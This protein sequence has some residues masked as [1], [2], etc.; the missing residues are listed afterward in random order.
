MSRLEPNLV[1]PPVIT[2]ATAA[3]L[4]GMSARQFRDAVAR[5]RIP[6]MKLGQRTVVLVAD[7]QL[8]AHHNVLPGEAHSKPRDRHNERVAAATE[9]D[10]FMASIE[11]LDKRDAI[12]A[13]LTRIG[14]RLSDEAYQ[15]MGPGDLGRRHQG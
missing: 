12:N 8:L 3:A 14:R 15:A 6:F 4:L 9:D 11:H 10:D 1:V 5:Q 13:I 7:L 2:D